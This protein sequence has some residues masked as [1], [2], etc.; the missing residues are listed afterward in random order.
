MFKTEGVRFDSNQTLK[1][2]ISTDGAQL[3]QSKP[4]PLLIIPGENYKHGVTITDDFDVM[5]ATLFRA[6]ITRNTRTIKLSP[7][8]SSFIGDKVQ[9]SGTPEQTASLYL[10]T[11]SPR[12]EAELYQAS[13]EITS[14]SS[15]IQAQ[16]QQ[17]PMC[18]QCR[19]VRGAVYM[20]LG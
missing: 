2:Q 20:R 3:R 13:G 18:V 7:S 6:S 12:A 14:V 8:L 5:I 15:R 17:L 19:I 10:Q 16:P 11:V 1:P 9:L 4:T